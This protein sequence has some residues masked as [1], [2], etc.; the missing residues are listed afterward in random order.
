MM[1]GPVEQAEWVEREISARIHSFCSLWSV[2]GHFIILCSVNEVLVDLPGDC[3][4][5]DYFPGV[6]PAEDRET[7]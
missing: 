2:S 7:G 3:F 6:F 5:F 1:Y 4:L